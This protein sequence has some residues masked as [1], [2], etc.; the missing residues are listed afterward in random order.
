MPFDRPFQLVGQHL[1][2]AG[3]IVTPSDVVVGKHGDRK[4]RRA[5]VGVDVRK[6]AGQHV[7]EVD[8]L[9]VRK[10]FL[11]NAFRTLGHHRQHLDQTHRVLQE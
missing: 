2:G 9:A 7:E 4:N 11:E 3:R 5:L 8:D 6:G 1:R 10:E